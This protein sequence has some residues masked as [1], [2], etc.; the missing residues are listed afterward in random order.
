MKMGLGGLVCGDY[1]CDCTA[2][3]K[4]AVT[5]YAGPWEQKQQ[6]LIGLVKK[7]EEPFETWRWW[8]RVMKQ[9]DMLRRGRKV[10]R[11][12]LYVIAR[13]V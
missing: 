3:T 5:H 6:T 4:H 12:L 11:T 10:S 1:S 8:M 2:C 7:A 13:S 9:W